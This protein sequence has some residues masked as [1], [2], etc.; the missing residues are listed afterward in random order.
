MRVSY[1]LSLD[2]NGPTWIKPPPPSRSQSLT[3]L[4]WDVL[5][6]LGYVLERS[7]VP[8]FRALKIYN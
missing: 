2:R 4:G 7:T 1:I 5:E 8:S 6:E 3:L